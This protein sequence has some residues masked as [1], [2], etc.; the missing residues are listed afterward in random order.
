MEI[1]AVAHLYVHSGRGHG[2]HSGRSAAG[3]E[4]HQHEVNETPL[5]QVDDAGAEAASN[6]GS[7]QKGVIGLLQDGH[8]KG[9]AAVRLSIN[10]HNELSALRQEEVQTRAGEAVASLDENM[11]QAL[12]AIPEGSGEERVN[13]INTA[14]QEFSASVQS[15]LQ[16]F[17]SAGIAHEGFMVGLETAYEELAGKVKSVLS[18]A[19]P[20]SDE[21]DM[22]GVEVDAEPASAESMVTAAPE[23][24]LEQDAGIPGPAGSM[25]PGALEYLANLEKVFNDAVS[26]MQTDLPTLVST[27]EFLPP[28]GNGGAFE[29]FIDLYTE[30]A[31]AITG[32]AGQ[33]VD[34]TESGMAVDEQV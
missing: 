24:V 22:G 27:P 19:S 9:V 3:T 11:T 33:I 30:L 28:N 34:E 2:V 32:E 1:S 6:A 8:F 31:A 15:I 25:E 16:E 4:K 7:R 21:P 5:Q 17:Q 12:E 14:Q 18:G 26:G 23:N 10:F 20:V 29:K 13:A